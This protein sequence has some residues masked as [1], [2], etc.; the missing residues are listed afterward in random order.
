M[1]RPRISRIIWLTLAAIVGAAPGLAQVVT[2]TILGTVRDAA[3]G[4]LSTATVTCTNE[5]TG[6]V[7]SAQTDVSGNYLVSN[8]PVG[9]YTVSASASGFAVRVMKGIVLEVTQQARIDFE[10]SVASVQQEIT[11]SGAAPILNTENASIGAVVN[12]RQ[13]EELPLNVRNFMAF[14]TLT[15]GTNESQPSEFRKGFTGKD[16]APSVAGLFPEM[17]EYRLDGTQNKE[18]FFNSYSIAPP[19]DSIQEFKMQVGQYSAESGGGGA[20]IV[21]VITKS[22]TNSFHGSAYEFL[23]NDKLDARNFFSATKPPYRQNQFGASLG[24]PIVRN[25]AFFFG[26]Y[27]GRRIRKGLTASARVPTAAEASGDLSSLGKPIIDP[28]S[29]MPFPGNIIPTS[30]LDPISQNVAKFY[31]APNTSNPLAAR[32]FISNPRQVTDQNTVL[33]R[34][35]QILTNRD[36]LFGRY[37]YQEGP[38]GSPGTFPNIGGL[39]TQNTIHHVTIGETHTFGNKVNEF[40]FGL[41]RDTSNRIPQNQGVNIT[42]QLGLTYASPQD[43]AAQGFIESVGIGSSAITGLGESR[44]WYRTLTNFEWVD[45]FSWNVGAHN[46]KI[47]AD[48]IHTSS[49][50]KDSTHATGSYTFSGTFTGDGFADFLLGDNSSA[51]ISL[52]PTRTAFTARNSVN[53]FVADDWKVTPNLT[54]NIGLRY[55]LQ[56]SIKEKNGKLAAFDPNLGNGMGGLLYSKN[57][58]LGNFFTAVRPDLPHGTLPDNANFLAD[59]NNFAPRLGF[60]YRVGGSAKT[61]VRGGYGW[62]YGQQSAFNVIT[63]GFTSPPFTQWPVFNSDP[64]IP[65]LGWN[66]LNVTNPTDP[67]KS[68]A[69][70]LFVSL[71]PNGNRQTFLNPYTQQWS[72]SVGRSITSSLGVR[73]EYLGSKTTHLVDEVNANL[74]PPS[75]LPVQPRRAFPAY[76]RILAWQMY[77]DSNYNALLLTA[78][79]RFAK[80]LIFN[81]SY[82]FSKS[83]GNTVDLQQ[84]FHPDPNNLR[85]DKGS[86]DFDVRHVFT[87]NYLYEL[88]VGPGKHYGGNTQGAAGKLL[89]GWQ[90][91]GIVTLR[92]GFP[93]TA[94]IPSSNLNAGES[95]V[96]RADVLKPDYG[97]VPSSQRSINFWF[98]P[99]AFAIPRYRYGTA[100]R[101]TL[102]QPGLR[103]WD[104][105]IQKNTDIRETLRLEFRW[106]MF[107][108]LNHP[109]WG[110]AITDVSNPNF[111][112]IFSAS[113]PRDMQMSLRL[114]F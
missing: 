62:F 102:W 5:Q 82:T 59:T 81:A 76:G 77:G 72:F 67:L 42:N 46:L 111:G 43:P 63:N 84:D 26:N 104:V 55:E 83:L 75:P 73:A 79:Q 1:L 27:E 10:M 109:N 60:A 51:L 92:T 61:V 54:L 112:K 28:L 66:R 57:A 25:K 38:L 33:A 86:N 35:D 47:G 14:T 11:V 37:A 107:N 78:E 85:Q 6:L 103:N 22:G 93:S 3:G 40:R 114:R 4:L 39:T 100:Q 56:T 21:N 69:F 24:G 32:N 70:G 106:E 94:T 19:V 48:V 23:R 105:A 17:N 20:A 12:T 74:A 34:Y 15:A 8:L 113:E 13:V 101:N 18:Q 29:G 49:D 71:A 110:F 16:F 44:S 9:V 99:T 2:G 64:R 88:P 31:P 53:A 30:R 108:A 45:T 95:I 87:M 98:D 91:S 52:T 41:D 80:G 36:M 96:P 50:D 68:L 7:R 90:V 58:D 89:G 97:N 65:Q